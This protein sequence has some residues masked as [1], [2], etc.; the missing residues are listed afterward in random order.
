[1]AWDDAERTALVALLRNRPKGVKYS[2]VVAEVSLTES[3]LHV[4][5]SH[6][7]ADLLAKPEALTTAERDIET[8]RAAGLGFM[9]FLD[10]DYPPQL[11]SVHDLPP[12]LFHRGRLVSSDVAVSVVGSRTASA[13]GLSIAREVALGL[14]DRGVTVTSG[15]ARG[16]DTAAHTA[17][18]ERGGRAVA[19]IGTGINRYYPAENRALQDEVART[20]LLLSQFWPDAPGG[21]HTFPMRNSVMSGYGRATI[22]VEA[23]EFSGARTQAKAAVA[24]GRPVI[25]TNLVVAANKWAKELVG[26]PGVHVAAGTAEVMS[27]VEALI[28]EP[29]RIEALL[30]PVSTGWG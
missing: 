9:T 20:G 23:G 22:V 19:V 2:D 3:A 1:M 8:W 17:T 18:L 16:I 5:E 13:K 7:P 12:V 24:H 28:N 6:Y 25:L 4:W 27:L 21:K 14:V 11:R 10:A 29:G 15:L 30:T 26:Q